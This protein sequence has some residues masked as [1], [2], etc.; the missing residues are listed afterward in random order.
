MRDA[1][2]DEETPGRTVPDCRIARR[3][4][5]V[6]LR[7]AGRDRAEG[8]AADEPD[9]RTDGGTN[10]AWAVSVRN[11]TGAVRPVPLAARYERRRAQGG[12]GQGVRRTI[13]CSRRGALPHGAEPDAGS[14]DRHRHMDRRH[15]G[16]GDQGR[17]QPRRPDAVPDHALPEIPSSLGRGSRVDRR[18]PPIA[19]TD[20]ES[21]AA[22]RR[23]LSAQP[24]HQRSAASRSRLP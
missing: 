4:R 11:R 15:A 16:A 19:G 12:R 3:R 5:T 1:A 7:Y 6:D 10:G 18:V 21:A 8:A 9:V 20:P 13:V 14:R 22:E 17:H 24:A 23:S 2:V